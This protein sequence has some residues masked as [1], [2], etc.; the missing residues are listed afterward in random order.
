MS[1]TPNNSVES[2]LWWPEDRISAIL[3]HDY[4]VS[5]L[6][7]PEARARLFTILPQNQG[8]K[9]DPETYLDWILTKARRVFLI[10]DAVGVPDRIFALVDQSY[11]DD[12]L[13]ISLAN[14]ERLRLGVVSSN[15]SGSIISAQGN[16]SRSDGSNRRGSDHLD[17]E[18]R[19]FHTQ[20]RF[21][22]RGIEPGAHMVYDSSKEGVPVEVQ[23][24]GAGV[25]KV[26]LAGSPCRTLL[27]TKIQIGAAP[28]FYDANEVLAE[29]RSLRRFAHDHVF[30]LYASYFVDDS[31]YALF[32]GAHERHLMSF[33]TDVPQSFKKLP[34]E[35]RRRILVNWPHCL[36]NGLAWLHANEQ[37]HGSIRPSN[38]LVD[39]HDFRIFLGQF[40]A[41]DT[42]LPPLKVTDDVEMYQYGAPERWV[43]STTV[44]EKGHNTTTRLPSGGGGGRSRSETTPGTGG[45]SSPLKLNLPSFSWNNSSSSSSNNVGG[46]GGSGGGGGGGGGYN[47]YYRRRSSYDD[48]DDSDSDLEFDTGVPRS[49]RDTESTV[50]SRPSS[51]TTAIRVGGGAGAGA[52][53]GGGGPE[54]IPRSS[55][56]LSSSSSS[57]GASGA[58]Q[59]RRRSQIPLFPVLY[60]PPA[61]SSSSSSGSSGPNLLLP[62]PH[63]GSSRKT[64]VNTWQS[65]QTNA[66]ASD[67]FSLG[68]V[69]L[70]ILTHVCKRKISAF[71]NHRGAKN[72]SAGRGGGMADASFHLDRNAGQVMSWITLLDG[73]ARKRKR[74]DPIFKSVRG[75]LAVVR[76]MLERDAMRRISA[77]E[78]EKGFAKSLRSVLEREQ[79]SS[80][81]EDN[82][83]GL[84]C[85]STVGMLR[86]SLREQRKREAAE[87]EALNSLMR[88]AAIG[89]GQ[90]VEPGERER[91]FEAVR[92]LIE[93]RQRQ[94][95]QQQQP[96]WTNSFYS[97]SAKEPLTPLYE[98]DEDSDDGQASSP[99]P[100][101]LPSQ[102]HSP[103]PPVPPSSMGL[104]SLPGGQ[105]YVPMDLLLQ[106]QQ[107][108]L[109]LL[110]Q[111][112]QLGGH[113]PADQYRNHLLGGYDGYGG[114]LG[115]SPTHQFDLGNFSNN[116]N[117]LGIS[118]ATPAGD[119]AAALG[120]ANA[121]T[122]AAATATTGG[123]Q[124]GQE[125]S[126][127]AAAVDN[128]ESSS[129]AD[130]DFWDELALAMEEDQV[131]KNQ[132]AAVIPSAINDDD[133]G[134]PDSEI[135]LSF[136]PNSTASY[137]SHVYDP[138]YYKQKTFFA[139]G[140]QEENSVVAAANSHNNKDAGVSSSPPPPPPPPP[141][142]ATTTS[143][144]GTSPTTTTTKTTNS[145]PLSMG[146]TTTSTAAK[147]RARVQA[148]ARRYSSGVKGDATT[149]MSNGIAAAG[150][151]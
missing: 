41:L 128:D 151:Q 52:G 136:R 19:F 92:G 129:T 50:T 47:N 55:F 148:Q 12:D 16:S 26:V 142:P 59:R 134:R 124:Q 82:R 36:A 66:H 4:V 29:V 38:V 100:P 53:A 1:Y 37:G 108:Q 74:K 69:V 145:R 72:R 11:D 45:L 49:M 73:D 149:G 126:E 123:Q 101:P 99:P 44:Q 42:F 71:T 147:I 83:R 105:V 146:S 22:V 24:G 68:A 10:L 109:L 143:A 17:L 141:P 14:V 89:G 96:Q 120:N 150:S 88:S 62:P 106:Q 40:E 103:F 34:K 94:R 27:R 20:W 112:Q 2:S 70:D 144:A 91:R 33:L 8:L 110:Q 132:D 130:D 61:L 77:N 102:Y 13:P 84:H 67:V 80:H 39:H 87:Q 78:V 48:D 116:N 137:V 138:D 98:S 21:L 117:G 119:A 76:S 46:G 111:Q 5:R 139:A 7:H 90:K 97:S 122:P 30:S 51:P 58:S 131:A 65:H 9:S 107:Y 57:S 118:R 95:G 28:H 63:S 104:P 64:L 75:M 121:T 15:S 31:I 6:S 135:R 93:Q 81:A 56:A 113:I 133:D 43:L 25:E 32:S 114:D 86:R 60:G 18:N 3:S 23:R 85:A 127:A 79:P 115:S 140:L 54:S 35:Q 125:G